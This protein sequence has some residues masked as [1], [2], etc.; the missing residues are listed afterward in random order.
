[1]E[2]IE[3][4]GGST[5]IAVMKQWEKDGAIK[6]ITPLSAPWFHHPVFR[7]FPSSSQLKQQ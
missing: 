7:H 6:L 1:M 3:A 5:I 2:N 4:G